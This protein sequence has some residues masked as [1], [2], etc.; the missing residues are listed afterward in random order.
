[1]SN[2][3]TPTPIFFGTLGAALVPS[4]PVPAPL[5]R[6]RRR[7]DALI[8]DFA[9]GRISRADVKLS[10]ADLVAYDDNGAGWTIGA[11]TGHWYTRP[12][13]SGD[14]QLADPSRARFAGAPITD[15]ALPDTSPTDLDTADLDTVADVDGETN[16]APEEATARDGV[17]VTDEPAEQLDSD[18]APVR[19][20]PPLPPPVPTTFMPP[21]LLLPTVLTPAAADLTDLERSAGVSDDLDMDLSNDA[22]DVNDTSD[23]L[24]ADDSDA[25]G[26]GGF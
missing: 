7:F 4:A 8:G 18:T 25:A 9:A 19:F 16:D 10:L 15:P 26:D 17:I 21:A 12:G 6:L 2:P 22:A 23:G 24:S 3:S 11:S 1:M 5:A 20:A 13:R 14:W